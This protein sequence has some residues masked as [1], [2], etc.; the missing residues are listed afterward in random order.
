MKR[1]LRLTTR[2]DAGFSLV[3]VLTVVGIIM[4]LAAVAFPNIAGYMR[5]YQ[6]RGATQQVATA[7]QDARTR[8]IMRNANGGV[9]LVVVAAN[10]YRVVY[11]DVIQNPGGGAP[12]PEDQLDRLRVL[13]G[14]VEFDVNPAGALSTGVRFTRLGALASYS[15]AASPCKAAEPAPTCVVAPGLGFGIDA[16]GG[17]VLRLVDRQNGLQRDITIALGGRIQQQM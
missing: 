15:F 9:S 10:R 5:R 14:A 16:A 13:P 1:N 17:A 11:D 7:L 6:V 3:E 2:R 4:I 8:A 12:D